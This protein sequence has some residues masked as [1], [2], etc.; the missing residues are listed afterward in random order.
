MHYNMN[1]VVQKA[2]LVAFMPVFPLGF[3]WGQDQVTLIPAGS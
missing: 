3:L 2:F 1:V